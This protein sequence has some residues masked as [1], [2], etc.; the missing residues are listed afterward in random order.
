MEHR[1]GHRREIKKLVRLRSSAGRMDTGHIHNISVS[2]AW[3]VS[4]APAKL[5]SSVEV[6]FTALHHGG[7]VVDWV[8]GTIVRAGSNGFAVEWRDFAHPT[9]RSLL[10][11]PP[12]RQGQSAPQGLPV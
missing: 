8:H 4:R 3:M 2:G 12:D 7:H 1:W 6:G 10:S 5:F 11:G 9:I